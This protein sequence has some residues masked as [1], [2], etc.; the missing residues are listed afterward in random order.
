MTDSVDMTNELGARRPAYSPQPPASGSGWS[1][2]RERNRKDLLAALGFLLPNL[3][4]FLL[5]TT[6]PVLVS[7]GASFTNWDI[8]PGVDLRFVGLA[9][10]REMFAEPDF[11][12][13]LYNTVYMMAGI[14]VA[15]AGSLVLALVLNQRLR[16]VV[17]YR[18]MFY[19]SL[20]H[21]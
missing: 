19:L 14:P 21:I 13:Y 8:R 10:F 17:V 7:L 3:L 12:K 15:I 11:W 2:R 9:N 18:T 1:F 5:F 20:I 4:G 16:G 6:V